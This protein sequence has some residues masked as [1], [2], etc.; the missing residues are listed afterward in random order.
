MT[1]K[2][3]PIFDAPRFRH[4]NNE[5]LVL[6]LNGNNNIVLRLKEPCEHNH[7]NINI[8]GHVLD[9]LVSYFADSGAGSNRSIHMTGDITKLGK[10]KL[11]FVMVTKSKNDPI[12]DDSDVL[13]NKLIRPDELTVVTTNSGFKLRCVVE[14]ADGD[15]NLP[16]CNM[17][18]YN[19]PVG[20]ITLPTNLTDGIVE[21]FSYWFPNESV[22][23]RVTGG[24]RNKVTKFK[25]HHRLSDVF[26]TNDIRTRKLVL[27]VCFTDMFP[28]EYL[29]FSYDIGLDTVYVTY[30]DAYVYPQN[31]N[32]H[33]QWT[34]QHNDQSAENIID[35]INSRIEHIDNFKIKARCDVQVFTRYYNDWLRLVRS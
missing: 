6:T 14:Y 35:V 8:G 33:A 4:F 20:G 16:Y 2:N 17:Q 15:K 29:T 23:R 22:A 24:R 26:I 18:I 7:V 25:E 19:I 11:N 28:S 13:N 1:I 5:N 9:D 30:C 32:V 27:V 10:Y 34:F 3:L 31:V 12:P 21:W